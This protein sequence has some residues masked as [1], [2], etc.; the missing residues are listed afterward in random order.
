MKARKHIACLAM[1]AALVFPSV[2][3]AYICS[4]AVSYLGIDASGNVVVRVGPSQIHTICNMASQGTF[5]MS[6]PSCKAAYASLVAARLASKNMTIYYTDDGLTCE[7]IPNWGLAPKT[8]FV[9]GPE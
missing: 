7:T 8:Y 2:S 1:T 3:S 4:G 6:V 9:Q 5:A